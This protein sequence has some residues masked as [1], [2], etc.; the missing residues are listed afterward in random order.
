MDLAKDAAAF[1]ALQQGLGR[2]ALKETLAST[3]SY[4]PY[5]VARVY[6]VAWG[7][8]GRRAPTQAV[9]DHFGI[10]RSAASKRVW[11]VRN[12]LHLLP[13]TTQGKVPAATQPARKGT[14]R[15]GDGHGL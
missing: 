6:K 2:P 10:S 11:T 5:E 4:D 14:V 13:P 15:K 8:H 9:A 12:K 7:S 3:L 1:A